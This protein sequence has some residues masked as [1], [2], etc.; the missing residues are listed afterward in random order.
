MTLTRTCS[1]IEEAEKDSRVAK[2]RAEYFYRGITPS[3][4]SSKFIT[5]L[6]DK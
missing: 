1:T 6:N 4:I 2:W 3:Q 5:S